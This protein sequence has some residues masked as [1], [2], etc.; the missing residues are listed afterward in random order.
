MGAVHHLRQYRLPFEAEAF[1]AAHKDCPD[2]AALLQELWTLVQPRIWWREEP[3]QSNDGTQLV[4]GKQS[5]QID[6]CYVCKGLQQC[7]RA[8][9][10]ALTIGA[11]LPAE[12]QRCAQQGQ[13]YRSSVADYLGSHAVELLAESFCQ[14]LQQQLLARGLYPTLRYSPGYGDWALE[15][16]TAVF[17]F[18][19]GCQGEIRLSENYLMEPVK[20]ITAIVG[21]SHQWQQPVYPAGERNGFCNGG[22]NCAACVTWACRKGRKQ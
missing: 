9:V 22:H 21:L 7:S 1:I 3:V 4:L 20:S 17:A 10:M 8:V 18:L 12:A 14:Y 16:Q 6:S 5:L 2:D 15:G 13:L 11:A 19:D